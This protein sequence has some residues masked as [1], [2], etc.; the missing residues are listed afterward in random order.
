MYEDLQCVVCH[1]N[2]YK[3]HYKGYDRQNSFHDE[4]HIVQC[5]H[6]KSYSLWPKLSQDESKKYYPDDY[7]CY[8]IAVEDINSNTQKIDKLIH[9]NKFC[10]QVTKR[11]KIKT[12]RILDIGCATGNFLFGMK[13]L[14]W[15]CY[16]VEPSEF[17]ANYARKR[18][19]LNIYNGYIENADYPNSFFDVITLWDVLE[20]TRNPEEVLQKTKDLL[21]PDG[22][23]LLTM[24][25]SQ[26]WERYLFGQYWAGWDIPRH[27]NIFSPSSI[28]SLLNQNGFV[29]EEIFGFT[30]RHGNFMKSV[31]F[32]L[33]DSKLNNTIKKIFHGVLNSIIIRILL[34]P[35]F[36]LS[37]QF[38]RS[39]TMAI[40]AKKA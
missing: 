16:G 26:S 12:G 6:C 36:I 19:N 35:I 15:D 37:E 29:R 31:E 23:L 25:N 4:F 39:S 40:S 2:N 34:Y 33:N 28:S 30:G 27:F 9:R 7:S 8:P 22:I 21:K 10:H 3:F 32:W 20:H 11:S 1:N 38:D 5:N 18:F 13:N 14:G 17:A 24:P